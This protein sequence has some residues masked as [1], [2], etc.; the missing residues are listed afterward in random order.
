[1]IGLPP[2]AG[3]V[4]KWFVLQATWQAEQY[5][6]LTI[7]VLSTVLNAG[8]FLPIIY[9]SFLRVPVESNDEKNIQLPRSVLWAL[10][11]TAILNMALFCYPSYILQLGQ[12]I[13]LN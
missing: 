12:A 1:M 9:R 13:P 8:Y 11:I 6:A 7:V 4:S 5:F 3:F 10:L 2:T